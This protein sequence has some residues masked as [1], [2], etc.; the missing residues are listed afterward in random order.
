MVNHVDSS[1]PVTPYES[2]GYVLMLL[3]GQSKAAEE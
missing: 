3:V 2:Q 1:S